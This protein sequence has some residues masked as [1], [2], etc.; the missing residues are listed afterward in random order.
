MHF[1]HNSRR[2]HMDKKQKA[3]NGN[4][5]TDSKPK[6]KT[7]KKDIKGSP[8]FKS[9]VLYP[10]K[11]SMILSKKPKKRH[12]LLCLIKTLAVGSDDFLMCKYHQMVKN[13]YKKSWRV[14]TIEWNSTTYPIN[15]LKNI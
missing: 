2:L 14:A 7:V 8:V 3:P 12:C 4:E 6:K 9:C 10:Q 11:A 13:Q 5:K 15:N 1:K